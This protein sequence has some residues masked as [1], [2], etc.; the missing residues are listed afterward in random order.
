MDLF[1]IREPVIFESQAESQA[2]AAPPAVGIRW[3]LEADIPQVVAIQNASCLFKATADQVAA[4][5]RQPKTIGMVAVDGRG[6]VA[7]YML[8]T[9][10]PDHVWL[11]HFAVCPSARRTGVGSALMARLLSK[12]G[13]EGRTHVRLKA[14]EDNLG[15]LRFYASRGFRA[16]EVLR[17]Y[18]HDGRDA[19]VMTAWI[20]PATA[21][22]AAA[23]DTD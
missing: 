5:N 19:Y 7:G 10:G 21:A 15:A 17:G 11:R 4:I 9:F 23:S 12:L 13:S 18:Y 14:R 1:Q 16:V 6:R 3:M 20:D 22:P 2:P 8:Y